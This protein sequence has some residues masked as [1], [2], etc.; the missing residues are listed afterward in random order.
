MS[1]SKN[2][3]VP[4]RKE[5]EFQHLIKASQLHLLW[6]ETRCGTKVLRTQ[7][8]TRDLPICP[9]CSNASFNEGGT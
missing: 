8:E 7:L 6:I 9:E 5:E 3:V 4:I 1:E 2:N